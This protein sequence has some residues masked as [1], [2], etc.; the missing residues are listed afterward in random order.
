[1][2]RYQ[3]LAGGWQF[4]KSIMLKER[5]EHY[6]AGTFLYSGVHKPA[7]Y[8]RIPAVRTNLSLYAVMAWK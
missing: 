1:M 3:F 2:V 7:C 8:V 4:L 6:P 5:I